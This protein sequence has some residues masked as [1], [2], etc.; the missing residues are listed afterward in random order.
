MTAKRPVH[1]PVADGVWRVTRGIPM[2]INVFLI[3]D[4]DGVAVFDS[5]SRQ[6][7]RVVRD[8]A[9]SLGGASRVIV[10]NAHPDHRG[11]AREI[12]APVQCHV[13][14]RGH[15]EGD[16]GTHYFDYGLLPFFARPLIPRLM[17]SMDA[18]PLEV[19]AMSTRAIAWATSRSSICRVTLPA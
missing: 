11:G 15:L 4:G 16:G 10:G 17:R 5:G 2:R 14:E 6:M 13:D 12:G 7:G 3:R 9:A 18:G 8:A 1:V 19:A